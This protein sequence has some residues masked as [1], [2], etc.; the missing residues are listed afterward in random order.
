MATLSN[1]DKA[2]IEHATG[3]VST[4]VYELVN[5]MITLATEKQQQYEKS[6]RKTVRLFDHEISLGDAASKTI[7]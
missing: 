6:G 2:R 7:I 3:H 4:P 5:E 1:D